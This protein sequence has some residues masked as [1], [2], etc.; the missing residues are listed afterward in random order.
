M[1]Y[2]ILPYLILLTSFT[3]YDYESKSCTDFKL[4]SYKIFMSEDSESYYTI[5]RTDSSQIETNEYGDEVYYTVKWISDCSY[6]Q[7]FDKSKMKLT[8]EMIMV[9]GDGG[10]IIE[11]LEVIDENHITFR[12]YVKNFK[13]MSMRNG[14]FERTKN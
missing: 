9:N 14:V 3:S 2:V 1:K 7:K 4:G 13:E 5:N 8:D 12:S 11:L 10:M 6:V